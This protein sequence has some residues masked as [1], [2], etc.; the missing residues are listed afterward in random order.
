MC[1]VIISVP[2]DDTQPVRLLAVRDEDPGRPW[3]RLGP[4]WPETYP[5]VV[6]IRDA[7]AGGAWL[8]AAPEERR[9]AVL[10]NRHDLS[11][12]GDDEVTTRGWVALESVSGRPPAERPQTRG[13]NLVEVTEHTARV[14]SWNGLESR[15]VDLE[16]GTHM[17]AHDDV[18][19][20]AT[21]RISRWL[22]EFRGAASRSF[23]DEA[24]WRPWLDIVERS[25]DLAGDDPAAIIR[26]QSFE[27]IP[28]YSLLVC[29]A[30]VGVNALEVRDAPLTTP[31]DCVG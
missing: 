24:W 18:D 7:R 20:P 17:I 9:L 8:A 1:T 16:P 6:G 30:T 19:D 25:A 23:D 4:W 12:R 15:T 10:L 28:S 13:F 21:A 2:A 3:D 14:V 26:R 31:G 22:P 27:G 29:V 11:D 5:G